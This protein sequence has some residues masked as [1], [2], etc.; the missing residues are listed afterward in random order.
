M[1]CI[2]FPPLKVHVVNVYI[3]FLE[4]AL[5]SMCISLKEYSMVISNFLKKSAH[6]TRSVGQ[7]EHVV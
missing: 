6:I 2:R 1:I 4:T 3:L 7:Y 5:V